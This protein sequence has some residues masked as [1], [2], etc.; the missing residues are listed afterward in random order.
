MNLISLDEVAALNGFW[1]YLFDGFTRQ[2]KP[3]WHVFKWAFSNLHIKVPQQFIRHFF[4]P[5]CLISIRLTVILSI[6][7]PRAMGWFLS[8]Y[9][10]DI[11]GY[12]CYSLWI[13]N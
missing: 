3:A 8:Q 2:N 5:S 13:R 7:T 12:I 6:E 4:S 11:K 10:L 1:N 9:L